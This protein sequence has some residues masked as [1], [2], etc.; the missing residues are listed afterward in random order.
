MST[1]AVPE[2]TIENPVKADVEELKP[3][4]PTGTVEVE[5]VAEAAPQD[6]AE[7]PVVQAPMP[8]SKPKM[9]AAPRKAMAKV[10]VK[11]AAP[12]KQR[13]VAPVVE[14]TKEPKAKK[15]ASPKR[16]QRDKMVHE[17]FALLSS[18]RAALKAV[19]RE[20]KKAGRSVSK[21]EVVR[22]A[23]GALVVR[24]TD[25]ISA[26]VTALPVECKGK[27]SKKK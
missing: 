18:E 22:A 16:P 13:Q 21:S 14:Q 7:E 19:R 6:K 4:Q 10:A 12:A 20:L 1:D 11:P 15:A 23:L 27:R 24:T 25:D 8:V 9:K 2:V 26:L 5:P 3:V 17:G